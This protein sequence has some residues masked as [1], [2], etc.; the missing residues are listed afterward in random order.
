L[1]RQAR[2]LLLFL[3]IDD[4]EFIFYAEL[5]ACQ[6]FFDEPAEKRYVRTLI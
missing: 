2:N 3:E 5:N 1:N 6:G 4:A